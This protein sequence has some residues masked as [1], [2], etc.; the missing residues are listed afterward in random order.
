MFVFVFCWPP[1]L[2]VPRNVVIS[3]FGFVC[4]HTFDLNPFDQTDER[5][6]MHG[7]WPLLQV[8]LLLASPF[9]FEKQQKKQH[10]GDVQAVEHMCEM[11]NHELMFKLLN[12]RTDCKDD[13]CLH[14][15]YVVYTFLRQRFQTFRYMN[16]QHWNMESNDWFT[17]HCW[18]FETY[19]KLVSES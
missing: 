6:S 4:S 2:L 3:V 11:F 10:F 17:A 12:F 7:I 1:P 14:A 8:F 18:F 15:V 13:Q 9:S 19:V 16:N 5:D